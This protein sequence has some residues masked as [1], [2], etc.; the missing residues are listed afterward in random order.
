MRVSN[1]ISLSWY[2][3]LWE[4]TPRYAVC[5]D[6]VNWSIAAYRVSAKYGAIV[7][8]DRYCSRAVEWLLLL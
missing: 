3:F 5:H 4:E 2:Q 6:G 1:R 8:L 7:G